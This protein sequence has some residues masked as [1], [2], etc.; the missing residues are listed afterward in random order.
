MADKSFDG[1]ESRSESV[2]QSVKDL[3]HSLHNEASIIRKSGSGSCLLD[4]NF[5]TLCSLLDDIEQ[6]GIISSLTNEQ[7]SR[8]AD[9][10]C[11]FI[12]ALLES[13]LCNMTL[14]IK[15]LA[16]IILKGLI[17]AVTDNYFFTIRQN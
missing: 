8:L 5:K 12:T 1:A 15:F 13:K 16:A 4:H 6:S 7:K 14:D 11:E 17:L 10:I 9:Q 2:L 3:N